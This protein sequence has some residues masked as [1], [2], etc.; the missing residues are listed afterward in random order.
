MREDTDTT[1]WSLPGQTEARRDEIR[2]QLE[3]YVETILLTVSHTTSWDTALGPP[4]AV[5]R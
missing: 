5:V 3:V 2:V 4:S 1:R